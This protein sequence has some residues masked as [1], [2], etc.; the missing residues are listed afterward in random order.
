M[1][2]EENMQPLPSL[3][4]HFENK[5][6]IGQGSM[7]VV[8]HAFDRKLA[9][10]V[11]IK[12][13]SNEEAR[14]S[15]LQARFGR[16]SKVLASLNHPNIVRILS[17]GATDSGAPFIVMEYLDGVA[18]SA[19]IGAGKKL[20]SGRF[21]LVCADILSGL[22]HAHS[23]DLIH[24]DIKPGNIMLCGEN[25]KTTAKLVDFGLAV[26]AVAG[27]RP[28]SQTTVPCSSPADSSSR[29]DN[30]AGTPAYMSPEQCR[31]EAASKLSEIYSFGCVMFECL[32]GKPPF[33]AGSVFELMHKHVSE[34]APPLHCHDSARGAALSAL[35]ARCLAKNPAER[36]QSAAL[37]KAEI[38]KIYAEG[39][40]KLGSFSIERSEKCPRRWWIIPSL[41]FL[42]LTC[43]ICW[44]FFK[45]ENTGE[46]LAIDSS[47]SPSRGLEFKLAAVRRW[48]NRLDSAKDTGSKAELTESLIDA[49][50]D[51]CETRRVLKQD[52]EAE[53]DLEPA[54]I[55]CKTLGKE[56][57]GRLSQCLSLLGK[58]KYR[59]GDLR[60]A[61]KIL[62]E[63]ED[64]GASVWGEAHWTVTDI[65][66]RQVIID[67]K[68]AELDQAKKRFGK[69]T[70]LWATMP[71][72]SL[73]STYTPSREQPNVERVWEIY[74]DL[75]E[76][77]GLNS[78]QI[79]QRRDFCLKI[80]SWLESH[81]AKGKA[82]IVHDFAERTEKKPD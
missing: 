82:K 57:N 36:P 46:N 26:S 55:L 11:A 16:E 77:K 23:H 50:M 59:Q 31:G 69:L 74:N 78:T 12:I 64:L 37:L 76:L 8:I 79:F 41:F 15:Q 65:I 73:M 17:W 30:R 9:R 1:V 7:G 53:K 33:E 3:P 38:E 6:I 43:L 21:H 2:N 47:K 20:S 32:A 81:D 49:I 48:R 40:E 18:L 60:S 68:L 52:K 67:V 10:D 80:A 45:H 61:Q 4:A 27:A 5:G 51:C 29:T 56:G 70:G 19:E 72:I 62:A 14:N 44:Y 58:V 35:I 63:A 66:F 22:E 39:S 24:R 42:A 13:F 25:G 75:M 71:Q 54:L 28:G 34:P